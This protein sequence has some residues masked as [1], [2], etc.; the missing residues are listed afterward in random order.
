MISARH[1]QKQLGFHKVG[2][3]PIVGEYHFVVRSNGFM[4]YAGACL[5]A[6]FTTVSRLPNHMAC[7][8]IIGVT[9]W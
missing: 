5:H 1:G 7:V 8:S 2:S 9:D 6:S 3:T 4:S